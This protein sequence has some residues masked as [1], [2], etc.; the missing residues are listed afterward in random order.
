MTV[1]ELQKKLDGIDPKTHIVVSHE[2]DDS[3]TFFE[4]T[5]ASL[6]KG[7]PRRHEDTNRAGF[8]FDK[9]GSANWLFIQIEEA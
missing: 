3:M 4:V 7:N 5:E 9:N 8:T 6:S 1:A 2:T